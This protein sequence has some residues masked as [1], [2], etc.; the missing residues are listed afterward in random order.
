MRIKYELRL[1]SHGLWILCLLKLMCT[2]SQPIPLN[3]NENE[4]V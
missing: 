2:Y 3:I 1:A 4:N